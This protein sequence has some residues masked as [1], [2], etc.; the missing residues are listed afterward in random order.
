MSDRIKFGPVVP[1]AYQHLLSLSG[2]VEKAVANAGLD[3]RL[4]E[5]VKLRVSQLNGC[6]FCVDK[7]S[8]D[9]RTIGETERRVHLLPVW[10]ETTCYTEQERAALELAE[11]MTTLSQHHE[12]PD[13]VY[14]RAT[15]VFTEEQY[16]AVAWAA[17]AMNALNRLGVASRLPLPDQDAS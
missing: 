6:A 8:R 15:S 4:V 13:A 5:L 3:R 16:A 1:D 12:V 9:A 7:H 11:A 10:R 2:A 17:T 14:E